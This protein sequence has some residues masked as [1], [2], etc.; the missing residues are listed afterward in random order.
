MRYN[1]AIHGQLDIIPGTRKAKDGG[2]IP[3]LTV[4][5]RG[6][7]IA[8]FVQDDE[9][10]LTDRVNEYI[11]KHGYLSEWNRNWR[12]GT[13]KNWEPD[14]ETVGSEVPPEAR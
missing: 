13:P 11:K 4:S 7:D 5:L 2:S 3:T 6:V 14:E 12:L 1:P 10:D 9:R 8:I